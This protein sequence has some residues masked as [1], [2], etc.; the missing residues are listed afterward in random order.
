RKRL[1]AVLD[2]ES[3]RSLAQLLTGRGDRQQVLL[4][5]QLDPARALGRK[6]R[7]AADGGLAGGAR[8]ERDLVV[9]LRKDLLVVGK[10]DVEK[11]SDQLTAA[12]REEEMVFR[13]T[14][15][16]GRAV[17]SIHLQNFRQRLLRNQN[18]GEAS[19]S[20]S[21]PDGEVDQ[22]QAMTIRRDDLVF[23]PLFLE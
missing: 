11:S 18:I 1:R 14:N 6:E 4:E 7:D 5:G 16:E 2:I 13:V 20:F 8:H 22:C 21:G 12:D 17:G 19:F 9:A 3:F 15:R 10:V 23:L